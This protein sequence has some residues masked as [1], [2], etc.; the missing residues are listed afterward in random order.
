MFFLSLGLN[1]RPN[2]WTTH[3]VGRNPDHYIIIYPTRVSIPQSR[4]L[5]T[6]KVPTNSNNLLQ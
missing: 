5:P 1:Q 2:Y 3:I 4:T 6:I